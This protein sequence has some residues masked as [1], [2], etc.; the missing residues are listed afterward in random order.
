MLE[1]FKMLFWGMLAALGALV[2]ESMILIFAAPLAPAASP[3]AWLMPTGVFIEEFFSLLLIGKLLQN[4]PDKNHI[5]SRTLFFGV[6]FS[7]PEILLNIADYP[8]LSQ[9]ISLSY[10]GLLLIHSATAGIFGYHFSAAE[11]FRWNTLFFLGLAFFFHLL[12]NLAVIHLLSFWLIISLPLFILF[13]CF[14][15]LKMAFL[16]NS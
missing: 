7:I 14:I 6:G 2:L 8:I 5:F 15:A 9:E 10:L 1:K 11:K 16:K 13:G 12:F 3:P 4:S